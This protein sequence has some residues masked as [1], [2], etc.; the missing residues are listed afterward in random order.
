MDTQRL[1][2]RVRSRMRLQHL[3]P[4]TERAYLHWMRRFFAFHGGRHPRELGEPEIEAFLSALATRQRVAA[5]TQGQALAHVRELTVQRASAL[6][7]LPPATLR[8]L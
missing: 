6:V 1:V 5:S 2:D 4:R 8:N 7:E 3:S